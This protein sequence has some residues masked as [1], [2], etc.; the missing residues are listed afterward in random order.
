M[1]ELSNTFVC[2][3]GLG[4][5]FTGLV[6]IVLICKLL[7]IVLTSFAKLEKAVAPEAASAPKASAPAMDLAP[8]EKSAVV[9]GICACIAEELGTDASNIKVLSFKR[10]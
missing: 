8:A 5:V 1:T 3:M 2:L 10:V 6:C 7:S 9:A 4:T